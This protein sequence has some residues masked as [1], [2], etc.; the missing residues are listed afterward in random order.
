VNDRV[1]AFDYDGSGLQDHLALYR[2]GTGIFWI[3]QNDHGVF[4]PVYVPR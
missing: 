3:L 4:S 1:F 2:P